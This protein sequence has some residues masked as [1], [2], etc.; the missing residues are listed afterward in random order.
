MVMERRRSRPPSPDSTCPSPTSVAS[1]SPSASSAATSPAPGAR[2]S[3]A[4]A[5]ATK[6]RTLATFMFSNRATHCQRRHHQLLSLCQTNHQ[7][8]HL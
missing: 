7:P 2:S 4:R 8:I 5:A 6:L 1:T 3:V